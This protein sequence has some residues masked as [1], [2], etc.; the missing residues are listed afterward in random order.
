MPTQASLGMQLVC[1]SLGER[2]QITRV[3][4][5]VMQLSVAQRPP[6]PVGFLA[7]L[8]DGDGKA[9]FEQRRQ[10][11]LLDAEQLRGDHGVEDVAARAEARRS[12]QYAQIVVAGV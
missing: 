8:A 11:D 4:D 2:F 10:T 5:R 9:A 3:V 6:R 12:P 1:K 7:F